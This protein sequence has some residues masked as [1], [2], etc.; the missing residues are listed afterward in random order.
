MNS[1]ESDW[2][3][4]EWG[5][6]WGDEERAPQRN[7][8]ISQRQDSQM[9]SPPAQVAEG[10]KMLVAKY[11]EKGKPVS[12]MKVQIK[13]GK[14]E[15]LTQWHKPTA[16]EYNAIM[17]KAKKQLVRGGVVGENVPT[18]TNFAA[19][20]QMV[21]LG[22]VSP[23]WLKYAKTGGVVAGLGLVGYLIYKAQQE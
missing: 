22:E 20:T 15:P 11:D 17:F 21:P 1:L 18:T 9:H 14:P 10:K 12:C 4:D 13:N 16:D 23:S 8:H 5:E 2:G 6:E 3:D 19:Q 7:P